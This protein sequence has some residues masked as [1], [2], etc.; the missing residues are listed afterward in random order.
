MP[1]TAGTSTD[2]RAL[3]RPPGGPKH[4]SRIRCPRRPTRPRARSR[5]AC[6][7]PGFVAESR[8]PRRPLRGSPSRRRCRRRSPRR[9][10]ECWRVGPGPFAQA[11]PIRQSSPERMHPWR[12]PDR[13][14][15]GRVWAGR[16]WAARASAAPAARRARPARRAAAR[17]AAARTAAARAASPRAAAAGPSRRAAAGPSRR[18][19]AGPPRPVRAGRRAGAR[20]RFWPDGHRRGPC[21]CAACR[22]CFRCIPPFLVHSSTRTGQPRCPSGALSRGAGLG[23]TSA[24]SY[25]LRHRPGALRDVTRRSW[26]TSAGLSARQSGPDG[27]R[28]WSVTSELAIRRPDCGAVRFG[29]REAF[30][31]ANPSAA[32][33]TV[34]NYRMPGRIRRIRRVQ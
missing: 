24:N 5:G 10:T 20:R 33:T 27:D 3:P 16:A 32:R 25:S 11:P 13:M 28:Q 22:L 14:R 21:A 29:A 6:A 26:C 15:S 31:G 7:G 8:A 17:A 34:P 19:A 1:G 2:A 9:S 18:A 4:R 30:F 23:P 12:G